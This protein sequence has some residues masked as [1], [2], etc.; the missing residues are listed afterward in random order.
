MIDFFP[1]DPDPW[2]QNVADPTDP[3]PKH[4]RRYKQG[5][6]VSKK[7]FSLGFSDYTLIDSRPVDFDLNYFDGTP[8]VG[9]HPILDNIF[10]ATGFNGRGPTYGPA[11][12]RGIAELLLDDGYQTIDF[13]R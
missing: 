2:I 12:G 4:F 10:M 6:G 7:Y 5:K 1:L 9:L 13:S 11:V 3:D 8:I